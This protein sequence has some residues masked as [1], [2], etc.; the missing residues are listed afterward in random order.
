MSKNILFFNLLTLL[1]LG[2]C[3]NK[4]YKCDFKI[5]HESIKTN[6]TLYNGLEIEK[7]KNVIQTEKGLPERYDVEF[8]ATY[9]GSSEGFDIAMENKLNEI[10]FKREIKGYKW[11]VHGRDI[12]SPVMP[13]E[14]EPS[15]WYRLGDLYESGVPS[16]VLFV[17]VEKDGQFK[18]YRKNSHTNW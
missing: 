13:F 1:L 12:V 9:G 7:L 3:S 8:K 14:F 5:N 6:C 4:T 17:Y 2:G 15:S 18:V 10:V 11:I 16:V